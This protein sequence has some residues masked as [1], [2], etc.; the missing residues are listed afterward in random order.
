MI[1]LKYH[2]L[3]IEG[4]FLPA[5]LQLILLLTPQPPKKVQPM[6]TADRHEKSFA[7]PAYFHFLYSSRQFIDSVSM[8]IANIWISPT[9]KKEGLF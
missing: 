1:V 2:D 6:E 9:F 8:H 7:P 3:K 4:P 5:Y